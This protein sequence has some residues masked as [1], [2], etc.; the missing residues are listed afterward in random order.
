M[1]S[2]KNTPTDHDHD[3]SDHIV[4]P[5]PSVTTTTIPPVTT[6][7]VP[8]DIS[9]NT[10]TTVPTDISHNIVYSIDVSC[11]D[12]SFSVPVIVDVTS[13]TVI[14][15]SGSGYK[16]TH[17]TGTDASGSFV[18]QTNFNTTDPSSNVEI[19]ETL[20]QVV[21]EYNDEIGPTDLLLNEIRGYA[22]QIQC[23]DFHGKGTVDDYNELF[24]AASRIATESKQMELNVDV[25]GFTEF[26]EAADQLSALF[27]GFINK[28]QNVSIITDTTFLTSIAAALKKIVNLSK[29][30][31]H[32][33]ETILA[34][35]TIQIPKSAHDTTVIIRGVMDEVNCA[36]QYINYF[37]DPSSNPTLHDA[38][39][40]AK[41]K[42]IIDQ[43]VNTIDNWTALCDSGVSIAMSNDPDIQF[44]TQSNN[45]LKQTTT[46]LKNVTSTLQAKLANLHIHC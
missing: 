41:E 24:L 23:P 30:F 18:R 36:M 44:I 38:A 27:T 43:A 2:S 12:A 40:T 5:L 22:S 15:V 16:I 34:T 7:T 32:F 14:D 37:V 8:T 21:A 45:Q 35:S 20:S 26:G 29:I 19:A 39:L 4:H 46:T 6:T 10:T 3:S 42:N 11:N 17:A 25:E 9:H 13:Q 33:K 28:L 1:S 31:G